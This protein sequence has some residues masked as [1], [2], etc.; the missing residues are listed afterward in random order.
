MNANITT[1]SVTLVC[2]LLVL[3]TAD[4][5][6]AKEPHTQVWQDLGAPSLSRAM[7]GIQQQA[8]IKASNS[9][10][11]DL[12]GLSVS[13]SGDTLAIGAYGED[14]AAGA[15][16][17]FTQSA[18]VWSQQAYIKASNSEA[19]DRFGFSVS[20]SGDTLVVGAYYEDSD[21]T[22]V[23]GDEMSSSFLYS[24]AAYVFTR[25]T[26]VWSQQAY[27]K[28][29]NTNAGDNFGFSV[30]VSGNVVVVGAPQEDSAASGVDGDD[31]NNS[32]AGSGAAYIFVRTAGVWVQKAYLKAS[33]TGGNDAFGETIAIS[34]NTVVIGAYGEDSNAVGV[35][36]VENNNSANN[37]GAA[38][39]FAATETGIWSQQAYLKASNRTTY[40]GDSVAISGN[41]VV[42][43]SPWESSNAIGVN[44]DQE[45]T[46][47]ASSGAVYVF[48]QQENIW[49]QQAYIK[50]SNTGNGDEFGSTV[51]IFGDGLVIGARQEDSDAS[52]VNGDEMN[53]SVSGSGA[54]YAFSRSVDSIWSQQAYIKASNTQRFD[55][56]SSSV[57]VSN[58]T[59]VVGAHAEDSNAAGVGGDE[60]NNSAEN[61]G[62]VYVFDFNLIDSNLIFNNGFE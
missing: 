54:V 23:D 55:Y 31:S 59:L 15:V 52:G 4:S 53:N 36:G 35:D 6:L 51:S 44:G 10:R 5:V 18:G 7:D 27:L 32:R 16:Y 26:G 46:S 29:S 9:E 1:P 33:N 30:A 21:A 43:G 49:S 50:A 2:V 47:A 17:I 34:D 13:I 12:F 24:G 48:T 41:T 39:I 19:N 56:F 62:A 3:F 61:S 28:A 42:V 25:T 37:S 57:S 60:T 8:Y 58:D 11:G 14:G 22:G 40:F 38:Y 20:I 45:N